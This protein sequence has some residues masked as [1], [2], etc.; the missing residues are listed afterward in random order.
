M[1]VE[2]LMAARSPALMAAL[3]AGVPTEVAVPARSTPRDSSRA[4]HLR[5]GQDEGRK[6]MTVYDGDRD[7]RAGHDQDTSAHA[8]GTPF[9]IDK[10]TADQ[11][12]R[13]TRQEPIND[14]QD[15]AE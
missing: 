10:M 1:K 14:G 5:S 7:G 12:S 8:P 3:R 15:R 13:R 9:V 2:K 6:P 4:W 11:T